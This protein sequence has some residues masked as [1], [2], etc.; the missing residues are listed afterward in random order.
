MH[1]QLVLQSQYALL[2]SS[3]LLS[4][5]HALYSLKFKVIHYLTYIGLLLDM[6]IETRV[7]CVVVLPHSI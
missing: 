1:V 6:N 3:T 2:H 7:H 5:S 4:Q